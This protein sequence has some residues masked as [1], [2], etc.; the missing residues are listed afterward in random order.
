[1]LTGLV[2]AFSGGALG[3]GRMADIGPSAGAVTVAAMLSMG[4]GGLVGA[5]V[6][7]FLHRRTTEPEEEPATASDVEETVEVPLAR[8][9]AASEP[10]PDVK[11][12]V[13]D[14]VEVHLHDD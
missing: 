3:D 5:L 1:V 2:T 12:D 11:D 14:T 6:T 9:P 7:T 13:E 4:L 8:T 10:A